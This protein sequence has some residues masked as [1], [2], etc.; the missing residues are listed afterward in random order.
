MTADVSVDEDLRKT[1]K[2]IVSKRGG[3]VALINTSKAS[4]RCGTKRRTMRSLASHAAGLSVT[5][6]RA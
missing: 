1:G 5:T 6:C 2:E 3:E 4:P